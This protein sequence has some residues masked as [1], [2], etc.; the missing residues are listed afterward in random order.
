MAGDPRL[1]RSPAVNETAVGDETFLVEPREQEIYYLDAITSALWRCL[2]DPR[3][4][5]EIEQLFI[6]AFPDA[7]EKGVRDDL[8]A[9]IDD[10]L[11][12]GLI[13]SVP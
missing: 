8:E 7:D 2:A 6:E 5:A 10:M 12:R 11:R 9:A 1:K 3:D 4:K 13:V